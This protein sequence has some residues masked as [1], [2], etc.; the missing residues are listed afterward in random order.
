M[1]TAYCTCI[2]HFIWSDAMSAW[3]V[4]ILMYHLLFTFPLAAFG[5]DATFSYK[6]NQQL[7]ICNS[8]GLAICS[9]FMTSDA[10]WVCFT[11]FY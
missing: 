11:C 3:T 5:V 10:V 4:A 8:D 1:V 6:Y 2:S 9:G 7:G